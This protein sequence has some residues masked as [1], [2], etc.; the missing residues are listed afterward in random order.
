MPL[1]NFLKMTPSEIYY[2]AGKCLVMEE[3]PEFRKNV[4]EVCQNDLMDWKQFVAI[5]SNNLILPSIY[6][7]FRS[8]NILQ[9]LPQDLSDYLLEVYELNRQ[10][11]IAILRQIKSVTSA[12]N[13]ENIFPLYF[14]GAGNLI[15]DVY[16]DIGE[17]MMVDIDFL[18]PE[19]D[20][21][22]S[23]EILMNHGYLSYK[24]I[25]ILVLPKWM[26]HYPPLYHPDFP[27][28]IEIHR[29][30][31]HIK[32]N[33][34]NQKIINTEKKVTLNIKGCF[35]QSF[36]HKIIQ[37]F[38][39]SQL[40]QKGYLIGNIPLRNI[41]DLQLFSKQFSLINT[42]PKI[43]KRKKAIAYFAFARYVFG[44]NEQFFHIQNWKYHILKKKHELIMDSRS[45]KKS[46]LGLISIIHITEG[47]TVRFFQAFYS[48]EI[49][50]AIIK[51]NR[52][53]LKNM[54]KK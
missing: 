54:I 19:K 47:Y 23:A 12:L 9:H 39:H 18:I 15:D 14:K 21:L 20:F 36:Q 34:Y 49:R 46:F 13:K 38:I 17:R 22:T 35:V 43:K 44:F 26:H 24:K 40:S 28:S 3:N 41:Y 4:L 50:R 5:C 25:D 51:N 30:P 33:W 37:N 27:A 48:K 6:L 7:K 32:R 53:R 10:R 45:F 29:M 52:N 16:S 31:T 8:H 42:L 2:F 11:N 1:I